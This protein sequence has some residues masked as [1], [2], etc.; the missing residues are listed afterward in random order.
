MARDLGQGTLVCWNCNERTPPGKCVHCGAEV[1]LAKRTIQQGP[2]IV[3]PKPRVYVV[4][5]GKLKP[6]EIDFP[7]L[8]RAVYANFK[9]LQVAGTGFTAFTIQIGD[10]S[11]FESRLRKLNEV[12]QE[13]YPALRAR[14]TCVPEQKGLA[15][16]E[17]VLTSDAPPINWLWPVA[18]FIATFI[19]VFAVGWIFAQEQLGNH[20]AVDFRRV[21][22]DP[23]TNL[24]LQYVGSLLTIII[25]HES[26]HFFMA[27]FKKVPSS[28]PYLLPFPPILGRLGTLGAFIRQRGFVKNRQDMFDISMAGP[29][30]GLLPSLVFLAFGITKSQV[31]RDP[32]IWFPDKQQ[33][34]FYSPLLILF[35]RI[36]SGKWF[37]VSHG[38]VL[39]PIAFAG[40]VGLIITGLNLLP[41]G[42]L[43]GGLSTRS[44]FGPQAHRILTI[45]ATVLLLFVGQ[46][47][48]A[49]FVLLMMRAMSSIG[50]PVLDDVTPPNK[51]RRVGNI[52][53]LVFGVL[54]IPW[55]EG[56]VT[57]MFRWLTGA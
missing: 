50:L 9:V 45:L 10:L 30:A 33:T 55:P 54:A 44:T 5:D 8:E 48:L 42:G 56:I 19:S 34:E 46:Y 20:S 6:F 1:T 31:L 32:G 24:A 43:D 28:L 39:H 35:A 29:V 37:G 11:H 21:F 38:I 27:Y 25:C 36:C 41:A 51:Q 2:V 3:K 22:A 17:F 23:R 26:G 47:V 15:K 13:V 4:K 52:V 53:A 7:K 49:L 16:L 18:L 40:F 57:T 14:A 12:A